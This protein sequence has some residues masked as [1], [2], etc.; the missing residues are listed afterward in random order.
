MIRIAESTWSSEEP[1]GGVFEFSHVTRV[2]DA[3]EKAGI[4]VIAV[5]AREV[6]AAGTSRS[7]TG[8]RLFECAD[9]VLDNKSTFGDAALEV[10]GIATKVGGTSL[11]TGCLLL[12]C[13]VMESLDILLERGVVPPLYMSA[14]VDGGPEFNQ[15]L[16][17]QFKDR[18]AE[19]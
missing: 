15:R 1:E 12:D 10:E 13:V 11:Y 4:S 9:V 14:N 3:C 17:D 7:K 19:Y 2:L 18:L 8:K 6:S 5:T 16:L